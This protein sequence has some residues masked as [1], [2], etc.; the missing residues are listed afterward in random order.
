VEK[1]LLND[2]DTYP[3]E[4]V[5][6]GVLKPS[7]P[8]YAELMNKVA[9]QP[10]EFSPH[11]R[12]YKDGAA[13]LCKVTYKKKTI[14]WLSVWDACF[15]TTFYFTEKNGQ[16]IAQLHIDLALKEAF[17]SSKW[18]GKLKPLTL[19]I[20]QTEQVKDVL[21]IAAYKKHIK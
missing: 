7:Y 3:D 17:I 13:W 10:F 12:F 20:E 2:P 14:F 18:I 8:A 21:E 6:K 1:P 11:W 16:G 9:A 15:K 4:H 5:L 19:R